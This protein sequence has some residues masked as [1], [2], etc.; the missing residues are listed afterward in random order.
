MDWGAWQA[1]VHGVVKRQMW[2]SARILFLLRL[3]SVPLTL[4]LKQFNL[5]SILV[6]TALTHNEC[7][8]W[9]ESL[10]VMYDSLWPH[11]L[12]SPWN[13]LGQNTGV[14]AFPFS[15]GSSQPRDW[16]QVSCIAG[17]SLSAEPQ[18]KPKNTGVG[19]LFLLQWIVPT[20][21]S[22]QGVL[23][24]RRILYQLSYQGSFNS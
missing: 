14:V 16:T 7:V 23:R 12:Y 18:G 9:S 2:L 24:C 6:L 22:N 20:Q 19:S 15:R 10:S 21:Q 17:S 1:A 13:S 4:P 11:G 3:T 5:L 8:K